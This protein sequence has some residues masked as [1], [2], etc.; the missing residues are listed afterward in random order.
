M[1]VAPSIG[2]RTAMYTGSEAMLPVQVISLPVLLVA[3]LWLVSPHSISFVAISCSF[4]LVLLPWWSFCLWQKGDLRR[5]PLFAVMGAMFVLTY[6]VPLYLGQHIVKTSFGPRL[7]AADAMDNTMMLTV[8]GIGALWAG[9]SVPIPDGFAREWRLDFGVTPATWNY[10][11]LMFAAASVVMAVLGIGA[12][13]SGGR[14]ALVDIE[15][16]VLMVAFLSLFR[17]YLNQETERLD[18]VLL[19]GFVVLRLVKA[20][21]SGW[22]GD[23]VAFLM[24]IGVGYFDLRRRVP[25]IAIACILLVFLFLQPG[26][27]E[28]R[29]HYWRGIGVVQ[30]STTERVAF[31]IEA[32]A[33]AWARAFEEPEQRTALFDATISRASLFEPTAMVMQM[34]PTQVPFQNGRLYRYLAITLI[35]RAIWPEKP[36]FSGANQFYQVAYGITDRRDLGKVSM[37]VGFLA[38]SY[39][40][41]GWFGPPFVVFVIG[42]LLNVIRRYFLDAEQGEFLR[43][44]GI[45][46]LP[47]FITIQSQ[48]VQYLA[49]IIQ[50]ILLTVLLFSPAVRFVRPV[51]S[52]KQVLQL[53][54]EKG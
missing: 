52:S 17:R 20:I 51:L 2:A 36:T 3:A 37:A 23:L 38:E 54:K 43:C 31:W 33:R 1:R 48:A 11:R 40:N 27:N 49:G 46:L 4:V 53:G 42:F 26:K 29:A 10:V 41:F 9:M 44:L 15:S 5:F 22:L 14:Q 47:N 24:V 6:V 30:G 35:P 18:E 21:A 39:I 25:K 28:F 16:V 8:I 13:G 34:T 19:I 50:A 12:L 7:L 45:A 32:S